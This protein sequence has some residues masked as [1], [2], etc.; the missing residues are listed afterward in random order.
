MATT[1]KRTSGTKSKKSTNKGRST[2]ARKSNYKNS[3]TSEQIK[4]ISEIY[5][6]ILI[7]VALLLF[8]SNFGVCGV[9]GNML[10]YFMFGAFVVHIY[11]LLC[12]FL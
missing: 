1:K 11:S 4:I 12:C 9:V 3:R 5:I 2:G 7:A 10:S 6:W 8:L